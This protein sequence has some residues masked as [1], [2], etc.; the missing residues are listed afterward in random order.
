MRTI[1]DMR[2]IKDE[3]ELVAMRRAAE[4]A[5]HAH[6]AAMKITK[7]GRTEADATAAI[8]RVY[9]AHHCSVSFTMSM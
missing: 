7:A 1:I 9:V 2:L 6:T 8:M 5:V 3:H 4:V